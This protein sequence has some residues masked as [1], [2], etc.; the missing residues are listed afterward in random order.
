M[1]DDDREGLAEGL[2]HLQSA[3]KELIRAGRSLLDAA[4]GLVDDP[5]ALQDVLGT[6]GGLAQAAA[7]RLGL[8]GQADADGGEDAAKVERIKLS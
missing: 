3:A 8:D 7:A 1:A 2:E 4:E 6:I 5:A